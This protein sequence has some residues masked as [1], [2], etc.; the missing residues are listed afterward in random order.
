MSSILKSAW[1]GFAR[2]LVMRPPM[3]QMAA[4]CHRK[5]TRGGTEVLL[6]TSSNGNWILPKG[7]PIRGED[8]PGTALHEAWEEAGVVTGKVSDEPVVCLNSE[9]RFDTGARAP[10][11]LEVYEIEEAELAAKYPDA[12]RRDRKWVRIDAASNLVSEPSL[13]RFLECYGDDG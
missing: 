9:K 1:E 12:E 5:S 4:L 13:K 7:W 11:T 2:P 8:G 6:V 10:C 3:L